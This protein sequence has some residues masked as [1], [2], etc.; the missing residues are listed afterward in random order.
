MW[1]HR[2]LNPREPHTREYQHWFLIFK[3]MNAALSWSTNGLIDINTGTKNKCINKDEA[4]D[5]T[6]FTLYL[7][8]LDLNV[9]TWEFS[10]I[11][12][13]IDVF[14]VVKI[15]HTTVLNSNYDI[16]EPQE[17]H[18]HSI[19]HMYSVQKCN[20]SK[21]CISLQSLVFVMRSR[22]IFINPQSNW[23]IYP[24]N[25]LLIYYSNKNVLFQLPKNKLTY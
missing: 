2:R 15:C 17:G 1:L 22:A 23:H 3:A 18:Q 12:W 24:Y 5:T 9:S 16:V 8:L 10:I 13:L 20:Q 25:L 14:L 21:Q 7:F 11:Q 4:L 6:P 19:N